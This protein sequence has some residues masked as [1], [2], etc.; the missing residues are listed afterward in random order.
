MYTSLLIEIGTLIVLTRHKSIGYHKQSGNVPLYS[1]SSEP[2][3]RN[4][5]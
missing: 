3:G 5:L 2:Q 1:Q 4:D